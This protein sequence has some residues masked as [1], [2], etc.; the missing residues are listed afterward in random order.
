MMGRGIFTASIPCSLATIIG[1]SGTHVIP[2]NANFF[3][4]IHQLIEL[5]PDFHSLTPIDTLMS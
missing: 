5:T 2:G 4:V 3:R 1:V